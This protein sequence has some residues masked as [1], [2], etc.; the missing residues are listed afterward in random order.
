MTL[1][2]M[3]QRWNVPESQLDCYLLPQPICKLA[4]RRQ[5]HMLIS[6]A[7]WTSAIPELLQWP[8]QAWH[9]SLGKKFG[10]SLPQVSSQPCPLSG[11]SAASLRDALREWTPGIIERASEDDRLEVTMR[12]QKYVRA[13]NEFS[14]SVSTNSADASRETKHGGTRYTVFHMIKSVM[15]ASK[16]RYNGRLAQTL[17]ECIDVAV[18]SA[19]RDLCRTDMGKLAVK[20]PSASIL[21]RAQFLVD[22]MLMREVALARH[23][24]PSYLYFWADSSTSKTLHTNWM[25]SSY[26]SILHS[27]LHS[28]IEAVRGSRERFGPDCTPTRGSGACVE[29]MYQDAQTDPCGI[30]F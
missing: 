22:L 12:L 25:V 2:L 23:R 4:C 11:S 17:G 15:F 16:L 10:Q 5:W 28:A 3:L 24:N 7:S 30:G 20:Q 27:A 26:A 29:T 9:D 13:L 6:T 19:L 18:P 8:P 21:N 14:C 1:A